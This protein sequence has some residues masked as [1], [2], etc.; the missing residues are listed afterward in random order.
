MKTDTRYFLHTAQRLNTDVLKLRIEQSKLLRRLNDLHSATRSL[1]PMIL[2]NIFC[3]ICDDL[4]ICEDIQVNYPA[5]QVLSRVCCKWRQIARATPTLWTRVL[6]RFKDPYW[7]SNSS[8]SMLQLHLVNSGS[9]ALDILLDIPERYLYSCDRD[10][11]SWE[12]H[13]TPFAS[14]F[15]LLFIENPTKLGSLLLTRSGGMPKDWL[16]LI[17]AYTTSPTGLLAVEGYPN[18]RKI[19]FRTGRGGFASSEFGVHHLFKDTPVP[20]LATLSIPNLEWK[21]HLPYENLTSLHLEV[22]PIN[23]CIDFLINC[24]KLTEFH[25]NSCIEAVPKG[26]KPPE[27]QQRPSHVLPNLEQLRWSFGFTDWDIYFMTQFRF[28]SLTT[29]R[30]GCYCCPVIGRQSVGAD[31]VTYWVPFLSSLTNLKNICL[32]TELF[33]I[34]SFESLWTCLS[35]LDHLDSVHITCE[36]YPTA[37][38]T[39]TILQPLA[40]SLETSSPLPQPIYLPHLT[41]LRVDFG[42]LYRL[43]DNADVFLLLLESRAQSAKVPGIKS[44]QFHGQTFAGYDEESPVWTRWT[45]GQ[46]QRLEKLT[47]HGLKLISTKEEFIGIKDD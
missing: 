30:V 41:T 35:H 37:E 21:I 10:T 14:I 43:P 45:E 1:P 23:Q 20:R 12:S 26:V 6:L 24:P 28:P 44:L 7:G 22:F 40:L 29:F 18:L 13:Y 38:Q 27:A 25:H 32:D 36:G 31:V 16:K 9:L 2:A 11:R 15:H 39:R 19:Q 42:H 47:E 8:V 33:P 17:E 46:R 4:R 3:Y 34:A 5:V